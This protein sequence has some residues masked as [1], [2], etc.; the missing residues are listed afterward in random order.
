M[1]LWF[2]TVP[3]FRLSPD[4]SVDSQAR[5]EF[6]VSE[7]LHISTLANFMGIAEFAAFIIF[8]DLTPSLIMRSNA[9]FVL[10]CLWRGD[11]LS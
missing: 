7:W 4:F 3:L 8:L 9:T 11:C 6:K 2:A 1:L 10:V 5:R